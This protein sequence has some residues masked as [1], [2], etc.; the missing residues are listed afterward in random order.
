[1]KVKTIGSNMTEIETENYRIL[2]SYQTPVAACCRSYVFYK[3]SQKFSKTTNR[4]IREWL[5]GKSAIEKPQE[6]FDSLLA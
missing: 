4:H 5:N 6:F 3:T 1:M 2:V